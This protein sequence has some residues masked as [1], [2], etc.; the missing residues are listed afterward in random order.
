MFIKC[1]P[2]KKLLVIITTIIIIINKKLSDLLEAKK[3]TM[4]VIAN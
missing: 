2:T 1:V 4:D 3:I